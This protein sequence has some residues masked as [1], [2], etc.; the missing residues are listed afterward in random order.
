MADRILY[1]NAVDYFRTVHHNLVSNALARRKSGRLAVH[2]L[3]SFAPSQ[4][5]SE[6]V[7]GKNVVFQQIGRKSR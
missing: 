6:L 2:V 3:V 7:R 1:P 4:A 5:G